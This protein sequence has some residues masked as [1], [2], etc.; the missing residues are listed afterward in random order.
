M[1]PVKSIQIA[2][3]TLDKVE[4]RGKANMDYLLGAIFTLERV[5]EAM[6][7]PTEATEEPKGE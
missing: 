5:I 6:K 4:V 1:D 2:I 3:N 7:E